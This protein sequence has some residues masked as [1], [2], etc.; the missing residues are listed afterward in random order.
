MRLMTNSNLV[1]CNALGFEVDGRC[2][3]QTSAL[4]TALFPDALDAF[5]DDGDIGGGLCHA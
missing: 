2:P 5:L 4:V 1:D 3:L